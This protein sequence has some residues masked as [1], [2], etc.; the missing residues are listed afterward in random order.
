M[1]MCK[2]NPAPSVGGNASAPSSGVSASGADVQGEGV[3]VIQ[4][5][6]PVPASICV[7]VDPF[8]DEEWTLP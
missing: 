8:Y 6:L 5:P 7:E 2:Q 1:E 3:H 4:S